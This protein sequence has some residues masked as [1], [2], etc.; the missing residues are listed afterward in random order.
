M[1]SALQDV[2]SHFPDLYTLD[3][4]RPLVKPL[5]E[6]IT[7]AGYDYCEY[8]TSNSTTVMD[9]LLIPSLETV[10]AVSLIED[11]L[12]NTKQLIS[13]LLKDKQHSLNISTPSCPI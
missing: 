1:S 13:T 10:R 12:S 8:A 3:Q 2:V 5:L 9:I 11:I 7:N 4:S 6:S